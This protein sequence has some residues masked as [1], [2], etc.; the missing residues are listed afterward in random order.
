M[1]IAMRH[2]VRLVAIHQAKLESMVGLQSRLKR[3]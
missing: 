3:W 2:R 1:S